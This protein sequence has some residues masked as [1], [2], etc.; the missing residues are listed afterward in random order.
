M[1]EEAASCENLCSRREDQWFERK[2]GRIAAKDLAAAITAFAN[3]DGGTIAVGIE[4]RH[5]DHHV[6]T[7]K[8]NEIRQIGMDHTNP[9]VAYKVTP[10]ACQG[11]KGT[12]TVVVIDVPP[13]EHVHRVNNGNCYL[14]VG[15]ETKRLNFDDQLELNY[16]KGEMQF[17]STIVRRAALSD[18]NSEAVAS[19]GEAVSCMRP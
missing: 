6:D 9:T 7:G 11:S 4:D 14:R 2:S 12:T 5:P 10:L 8:L 15:D 19:F 17:D 3:A 1:A 18:L 16:T 13:S